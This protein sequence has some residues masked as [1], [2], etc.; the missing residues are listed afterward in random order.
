MTLEQ[1]NLVITDVRVYDIVFDLRD[2][3]KKRKEDLFF[4]LQ[5][6]SGFGEF[7][8]KLS[9][10]VSKRSKERIDSSNGIFGDMV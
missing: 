5:N 4:W 8:K 10:K 3:L 1:S 2:K 7:P 9:S 6:K